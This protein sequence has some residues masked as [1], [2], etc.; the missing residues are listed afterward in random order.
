MIGFSKGG[1]VVIKSALRRYVEPLAGEDAR[2]ALLIAMYPW[3]GDLPLDFHAASG[4][5]LHMLLGGAG[6]LCR[7]RK[8]QG[9]RREIQGGWRQRDAESVTQARSMIGM[10]PGLRIGATRPGRTAANASMTKYRR[11]PGSSAAARS[12]SR[13]TTDRRQMARKALAHCMTLGVSGGYSAQV[14]AQSMQDIRGFV[15]EAFRQL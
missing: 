11:A 15:R 12:P 5:P 4:A 14:R 8:L 10:C 7:H 9:V 13:K 3:C 1:T 6:P 2:F